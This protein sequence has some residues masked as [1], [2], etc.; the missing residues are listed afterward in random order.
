MFWK[1]I[2][3][4]LVPGFVFGA[5]CIFLL[6]MA[7]VHVVMVENR[8]KNQLLSVFMPAEWFFFCFW[9]LYWQLKG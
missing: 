7:L 1:V 9:L 2:L 5:L 4:E 8:L 6:M 3:T